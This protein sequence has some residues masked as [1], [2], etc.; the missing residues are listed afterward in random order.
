MYYHTQYVPTMYFFHRHAV[1]L[2][3]E[4]ET[5]TRI[6]A[7]TFNIYQENAQTFVVR[8]ADVKIKMYTVKSAGIQIDNDQY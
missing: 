3:V 5:K 6:F 2:S 1:L 7:T 8:S 4:L